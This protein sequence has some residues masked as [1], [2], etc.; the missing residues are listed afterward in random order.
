MRAL[1]RVWL[2]VT[3][4]VAVALSLA[5][6]PA[7]ATAAGGYS[8]RPTYR[9]DDFAAGRAMDILPAGQNGLV[10]LA[11][12]QRF[13]KTGQRPPHSQDQ[14]A[15]YESL[16]F[17]YRS[18]TNSALGQY[19]LDESFGVRP[20]QIIATEHPSPAV[21]VVIYRDSHDIPHIY[22]ATN[23]A[24][25]FG[26]GYAQAQDR[27]FLMDVLRHYG[28]GTLTSFLGPS[29]A[30]EQ[31]DHDELLLAP[32]TTAQANAQVNSL[33]REYGAQGRL[34]LAMIHS[35]VR[36]INAYIARASTHP[37]LMPVE[38]GLFGPPKPWSPADVV[39]VASLIGGIFGDG[40]G[41]E[42]RNA[43]LLRYLQGQL[44][45]P[46]GRPPSRSSRS[47]TIRPPPRPWWTGRSVTRSRGT[48][49]RRPSPSPT[50][51]ARRSR[52]AP[53]TPRTAA[54]ARPAPAGSACRTS[55]PCCGS[56][57]R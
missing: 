55:R 6:P 22:G 42:V 12:Y 33:P 32:Y 39:A 31:M 44:G 35:Y 28:S 11:Q 15:P 9:A 10:N 1:G 5:A 43:A 41:G 54:R 24:L 34:A 8:P 3:T 45:R 13:Q 30:D 47:R 57:R 56:R 17:G 4:V 26:A 29:C 21:P 2:P 19:Y 48:S 18:L 27:L 25:A 7:L 51:P 16:E 37:G 14:L 36:G 38:Y 52:E 46:A 20:G 23:G 50:T 53:P 40:G 49:T